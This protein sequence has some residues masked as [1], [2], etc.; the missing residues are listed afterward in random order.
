[1]YQDLASFRVPPGFRGRPGWFVLLWQG[2]QATLFAWS[3]QPAYG[4]RR[5][6]LR[7]FGARVGAH[8]LV[9]P[10]ARITYPWKVRLAEHVWIGDHAELYSLGPIEIGAHAVISQKSYLCTGS[11]DHRRSDFPLLQSA[12]RVEDQAWIATDCFV[13]PGVTI[14]RGA[15]VA[16][17]STVLQDVPAGMI[18]A[19]SPAVLKGPRLPAARPEAAR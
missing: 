16:A 4:W 3:P 17:R 18:V 1:M 12:I 6:L 9:R 15:L 5:A 13:A 2:V 11:H 7:L 10:S 8:V 19:G 14:G